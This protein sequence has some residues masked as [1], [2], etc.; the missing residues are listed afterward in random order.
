MNIKLGALRLFA[1]SCLYFYA[2]SL[3]A[4]SDTLP[5]VTVSGNVDLMS[6]FVWRGLEIGHAPSIQPCVSA[7]WK[8]FTLG[9][10]GAYKFTGEGGQETDF[11]LSKTIGFVTVAIWD[12]WSF[13]DTT[14]FD[15]FNYRENTTA[16]VLEAQ[17]LLSGG[18]TVP[19]NFLASYFFYGADTSKSIYLE[20]QYFHK[21]GPA[22][23]LVF[24][25]Y[26]PKGT[27]YATKAAFVNIGCTVKKSIP[28]TDRFSPPLSLSLIVNPA[29]KSAYLV[30]GITL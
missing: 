7:S 14:A 1:M 27:Y 19:F 29:S 30:A 12:Y 9:A 26:Q 3:S 16:H 11:Y 10:W 4:Q 17:L 6:R 15:F 28:V 22:D 23:L 24:A 2:V 8:G 13:Y 5:A 18:E 20:L 25:G 21:L